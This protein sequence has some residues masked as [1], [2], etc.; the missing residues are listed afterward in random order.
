MNTTRYGMIRKK[1]KYLKGWMP[2][3]T[4]LIL[5]LQQSSGVGTIYYPCFTDGET[6]N[7]LTI[8]PGSQIWKRSDKVR[9]EIQAC[10]IPHCSHTLEELWYKEKLRLG[11]FQILKVDFIQLIDKSTSTEA[12][13]RIYTYLTFEKLVFI[14]QIKLAISRRLL[15]FFDITM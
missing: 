5:S 1:W 10:L 7:G 3:I 4:Y 9:T 6:Y 14:Q 11:R 13:L 8:L 2:Y 15:Y 12:Y